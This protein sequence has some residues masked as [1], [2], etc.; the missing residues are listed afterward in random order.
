MIDKNRSRI[1]EIRSRIEEIRCR[2]DKFKIELGVPYKLN[3][4][5]EVVNISTF[6][7]EMIE[8]VSITLLDGMK[9]AET[10]V[11]GMT[12]YVAKNNN[13]S[14]INILFDTEFSYLIEGKAIEDKTNQ[15]RDWF[16]KKMVNKNL[17]LSTLISYGSN[18]YQKHIVDIKNKRHIY[19]IGFWLEEE[20][21]KKIRA[22]L[23]SA[24][25]VE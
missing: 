15:I 9:F 8:G 3:P 6:S 4:L 5:D 12:A 16:A 18:V 11:L 19:I 10:T 7:N 17:A 23:D 2:I 25:L 1:E 22:C 14:F 13:A 20:D 21:G 24:K